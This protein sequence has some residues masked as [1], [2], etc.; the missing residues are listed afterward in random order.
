MA[1]QNSESRGSCAAVTIGDIARDVGT[2]IAT[3]NRALRG[4]GRI[5]A[6]TKQRILDAAERLGYRPSLLAQSLANGR[7]STIG[8]VVPMIGNTVYSP[9]V[10]AVEQAA[11]ENC[12]NIILCDTDHKVNLEQEYITMLYRRRVEGVII[13][14]AAR[15]GSDICY[16]YLV[17]LE[18]SG[19]PVVV[20]ERK[21]EDSRLRNVYVDNYGDSHRM[22]TH[23]IEQGH[24]R[25][26]FLHTG[27]LGAVPE[28]FRGYLRALEDHGIPYDASLTQ[29]MAYF[30]AEDIDPDGLFSYM[31]SSQR[32]TAIY[33]IMDML[34]IKVMVALNSFGFRVP[35]DVAVVGFDGIPM[36]EYVTPPLTTVRQPSEEVGKRAAQMLFACLKDNSY[37][38][39]D[40][41]VAGDLIVRAS[42]GGQSMSSDFT[43]RGRVTGCATNSRSMQ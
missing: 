19:I 37:Q 3:V 23:L 42:C 7:S 4:H 22:T 5:S 1:E 9:M 26:G 6:E 13:I 10:R 40:E 14:P 25:I 31:H 27:F 33:C 12:Y 8:V 2:S 39:K 21:I 32:P 24:K 36:S 18:K 38:S 15:S 16:D 29:E 43:A 17:E 34:A 35:E 11:R 28:R 20:M 30:F 41:C